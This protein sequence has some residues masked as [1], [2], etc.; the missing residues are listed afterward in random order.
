MLSSLYS[1]HSPLQKISHN[2]AHP[3]LL[4]SLSSLCNL[5]SLSKELNILDV[6]CATGENTI[7][8]L[9]DILPHLH[10]KTTV[11]LN[12]LPSND[13][14][15]L[16]ANISSSSLPLNFSY[17]PKSFYEPLQPHNTVDLCV[18]YVAGHWLK[19]PYPY[20]DTV[21]C[22]EVNNFNKEEWEVKANDDL[23][24]FLRLRKTELKVGG[25]GIFLMVGGG[26]CD[27]TGGEGYFESVL[28]E[29]SGGR[30]TVGYYL[31]TIDEVRR[32]VEECGGFEVKGLETET[33]F[34]D[35]DCG[36]LC[37][38]IHGRS[39][40]ESAG[41]GEEEGETVRKRLGE[42]CRRRFKGKG[43][44]IPYVVLAVKKIM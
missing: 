32:G 40:M 30:G 44:R 28:S 34:I 8:L 43:A 38:S 11:H 1:L 13:W 15:I 4:S 2:L 21:L 25:F 23:V 22:Q 26:E 39:I 10:S 33:F 14:K 27:W 29:A 17:L 16:K 7:T 24:S 36:D 37:W 6:G 5:Q 20:S 19:P 12:D 42:I 9:N 31:R 3:Y 18:S 35:E 41:M